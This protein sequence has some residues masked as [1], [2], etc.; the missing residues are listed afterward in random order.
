LRAD[1]AHTS[2]NSRCCGGYITHSLNVGAWW[3]DGF[4]VVGFGLWEN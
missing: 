2:Q 4:D 3:V 1:A